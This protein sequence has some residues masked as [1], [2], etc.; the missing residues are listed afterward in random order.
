VQAED[1]LGVEVEVVGVG[2]EV[3]VL[4]GVHPVGPVAAVPLAQVE[5]GQPVL[6]SGEDLVADELVERHP[7]LPGGAGTHHPRAEDC[8]RLAGEQRCHDALDDLRRVL[9]VAVQQDDDIEAVTDRPLVAGLLVPAVP[10]VLRVAHH[11]HRHP[12]PG[13]VGQ[14]DRVGVVRAGVVADQDVVDGLGERVGDPAERLH[15]GRRGVVRDDQDA[16]PHGVVVVL[17][18]RGLLHRFPP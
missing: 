17:A 15:Q 5:P 3:D 16:Y 4:E 7:T 18:R 1:D 9:A 13:L 8:V 10:E 12:G 11:G 6:E 2:R 14:A